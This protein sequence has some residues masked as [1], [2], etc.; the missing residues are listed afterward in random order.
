MCT[1]HTTECWHKLRLVTVAY[2]VQYSVRGCKGVASHG[3]CGFETVSHQNVMRNAMQ[4]V[5]FKRDVCHDFYRMSRRAFAVASVPSPSLLIGVLSG[6]YSTAGR[7]TDSKGSFPLA[8]HHGNCG[9]VRGQYSND[10]PAGFAFWAGEQRTSNF[11]VGSRRIPL[12]YLIQ[13]GRPGIWR[14]PLVL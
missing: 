6:T 11:F 1:V 7:G 13:L 2:A 3:Y 9:T 10:C 12:D 4:T 8:A 5:H 14:I